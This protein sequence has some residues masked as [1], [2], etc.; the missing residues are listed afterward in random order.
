[1]VRGPHLWEEFRPMFTGP[2]GVCVCGGGIDV[3]EDKSGENVHAAELIRAWLLF[4]PDNAT[5]GWH[6]IT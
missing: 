5:L 2:I 6:K 1:M 4:T 3:F